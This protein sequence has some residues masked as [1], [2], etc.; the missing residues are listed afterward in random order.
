MISFIEGPVVAGGLDHLVVLV[1]GIGLRVEVPPSLVSVLQPSE[2][3]VARI[4]TFLVVREDSLTLFGFE[5]ADQRNVFETLLSV[6]GIG[7]RLALAAIDKLG[8]DGLRNA[9]ANKDLATLSTISGVGKKTAERMVLEIGEKLGPVVGQLKDSDSK[10][11]NQNL[12]DSV[13]AG[14]EQ[15]GWP[16]AVAQRVVDSLDGEYADAESM[17]RAALGSIGSG[18]G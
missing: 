7:P 10:P 15:L 2:S 18:R 8:S 9:V 14:L 1:G 17:L 16:R 12:R 5:N 6:S 4:H 3:T 11:L 13:E